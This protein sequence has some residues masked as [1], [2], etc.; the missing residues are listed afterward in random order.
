MA[1]ATGRKCDDRPVISSTMFASTAPLVYSLAAILV[2]TAVVLT[3]IGVRQLRTSRRDPSAL[4]PLEVM[5]DRRFR[6]GDDAQRAALLDNARPTG[7]DPL[8]ADS[9]TAPNA[10]PLAPPVIAAAA[11][12]DALGDAAES[13][14][15]APAP[16]PSSVPS[17]V[18][19][20]PPVIDA[21]AEAAPVGD[22]AE[23]VEPTAGPPVGAE[24]EGAEVGAAA[25]P[26]DAEAVGEVEAQA[27]PI[28]AEAVAD[29]PV[30]QEP[31]IVHEPELEDP[32]TAEAGEPTDDRTIPDHAVLS[33]VEP[34]AGSAD[35]T[36]ADSEPASERVDEA[37]DDVDSNEP[38]EF[39]AVG[40]DHGRHADDR[41]SEWAP[42][43][44]VAP[45]PGGGDSKD[46]A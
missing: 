23:V 37:D 3:V 15:A 25:G 11:V 13:A 22:R 14:Q 33:T 18:P 10:A 20:P 46:S 32:A 38:E 43:G 30:E 44:D 21:A 17:A 34:L 1:W 24:V 28:E 9:G 45:S 6:K 7:A 4:G 35:S 26:V 36:S 19:L 39:G 2:A 27:E 5:D 16:E 8:P 42:L 12:T 41:E 31:A 29:E 40:A